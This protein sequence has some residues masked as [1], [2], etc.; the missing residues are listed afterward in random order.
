MKKAKQ[1]ILFA[2]LAAVLYGINSPFS[3][4]LL[5]HVSPVLMA[6]L[7]YFGAGFG[8]M[9]VWVVR[10]NRIPI[11]HLEKKQWAY[12]LGMIILD[13]LAPIMLMLGLKL[14]TAANASLLNNFE[15]V[16]TSIIAFIF[17]KEKISKRVWIAILI[18]SVASFLLSIDDASSFSFSKGSLFVVLACFFWGL[19]NNCTRV[20]S[21]KDPM[22]IVVVKG[23]AS[24][25]GSLVVAFI[26]GIEFFAWQYVLLALL[27]GFVAYG[28]S[29]LLYV[30][31]QHD[32]G[33]SKTSAF[34]ALAPFVGAALSFILFQN[35][36]TYLYIIAL[37]LMV[38]GA[39]LIVKEHLSNNIYKENHI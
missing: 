13:I 6:S 27:L 35:I 17:F 30:R 3:Q 8:M 32:L 5:Q 10:I 15:I 34:Y 37:I 18:I 20:L 7:L 23:L 11:N 26:V 21:E 38:V 1:A 24:G 25:F 28:M 22:E 39:N 12:I 33:A 19:E 2:I 9:I 14:T 36:P 4:L 29:I 16:A 31:A